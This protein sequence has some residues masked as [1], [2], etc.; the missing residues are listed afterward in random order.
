L[1]Q[2]A[3]SPNGTPSLEG[4]TMPNGYRYEEWRKAKEGRRKDGENSGPS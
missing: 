4:A 1:E 3:K 2:Q